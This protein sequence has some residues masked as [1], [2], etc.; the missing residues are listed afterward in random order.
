[1]F[2]SLRTISR[3]ARPV[4]LPV[5]SAI[6]PFTNSAIRASTQGY[7][8]GEGDPKAEKPQEQGESNATKENAEHPGPEAPAAGSSQPGSQ[9]K[10]KQEQASAQ[11][12]GSRSKEAK[13]TGSSPTGGEIGGGKR[14]FSTFA[15]R[16]AFS[17]SMRSR[18]ENPSNG[19]KP[20]LKS[21]ATGE[22]ISDAK[23]KEVEQHN[24]EF[25]ERSG[26]D[27]PKEDEKVDKK[28]WSGKSSL[29]PVYDDTRSWLATDNICRR[30]K[31]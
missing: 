26:K 3:V 28:F 11:S 22:G 25:S 27:K 2:S 21:K 8:D 23:A 5:T 14:S 31:H 13:E 12:G 24:K 19:A 20:A 9:G 17:T 15:N 7:G 6:R 18:A 4:S 30:R 29:C 10:D 1:M 16:R